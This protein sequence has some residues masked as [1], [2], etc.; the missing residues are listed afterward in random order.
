[1]SRSP[2]I[3]CKKCG[4]TFASTILY[5]KHFETKQPCD[6]KESDKKLDTTLA[7]PQNEFDWEKE[8]NKKLHGLQLMVQTYEGN[9]IVM[10]LVKSFIHS[11]LAEQKQEMFHNVEFLRQ[12]LNKDRITDPKKMVTSKDIKDWL[13]LK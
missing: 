5:D 6:I 2:N 12:W 10:P 11:L 4:W 9:V 8:F 13:K 3:K 1:M 7:K